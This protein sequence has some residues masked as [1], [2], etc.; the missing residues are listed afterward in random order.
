MVKLGKTIRKH[1]VEIVLI[2]LTVVLI[3]VLLSIIL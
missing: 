1:G 2:L 3:F